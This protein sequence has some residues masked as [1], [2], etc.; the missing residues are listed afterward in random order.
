[1][2]VFQAVDVVNAFLTNLE[3][4]VSVYVAR[5]NL[6]LEPVNLAE[7]VVFVG[8]GI[9]GVVHP[10]FDFYV[11]VVVFVVMAIMS[12]ITIIAIMVIMVMLMRVFITTGQFNLVGPNNERHYEGVEVFQVEFITG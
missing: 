3:G 8:L 6:L 7:T 11:F 1:M 12:M 4:H 5:L 2:F 10:N 9:I